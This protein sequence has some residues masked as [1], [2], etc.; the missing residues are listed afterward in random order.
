MLLTYKYAKNQLQ[1]SNQL[2]I[3]LIVY[4]CN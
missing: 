2:V 1:G 4:S 3:M